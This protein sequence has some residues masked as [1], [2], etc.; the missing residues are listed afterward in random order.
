VEKK[1]IN[2]PQADRLLIGMVSAGAAL[3][4]GLWMVI[5]PAPRSDHAGVQSAL[6]GLIKE[7]WGLPA[8]VVLTV[9]GACLLLYSFVKLRK[10]KKA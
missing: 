5:D 1:R 3:L 7:I 9:L 6:S 4:L 2:N 10:V 8:G